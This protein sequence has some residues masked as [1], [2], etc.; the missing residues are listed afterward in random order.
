[1]A[2][3]RDVISNRQLYDDLMQR[4]KLTG[5]TGEY[6]GTN[7]QVIDA[8]RSRGCPMLPN[9][10]RDLLFALVTGF[11]LALGLA[12]GLEYIDSRI[13]TPD[14][15][16]N[17]LGLPFLG[18]VPA[19]GAKQVKGPSPLLDRGVPAS[20]SEAMRGLRTSVI[21]SSAAE[22]SRTRHG[23]EHG[24]ERGQDASWPAI[25]PTRWRKPSSARCSSTATCAGRAFTRPSS[26]RRSRAC[27]TCSWAPCRCRRPSARPTARSCRCCRPG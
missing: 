15:I 2:L 4:A 10:Q 12:F 22:G 11:L 1:M 23:H 3:E 7:V 13:K 9:H 5:V 27:R 16:K 21:F 18:L 24:A 17:H 6:K 14:D 26:A 8:R 19:V 25:W 20:F